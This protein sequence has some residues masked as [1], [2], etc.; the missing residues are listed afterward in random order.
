MDRAGVKEG[1]YEAFYYINTATGEQTRHKPPEFDNY[2]PVTG[3]VKYKNDG[4]K[5]KVLL[6]GVFF[7]K[8][9]YISQQ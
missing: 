6:A 1:R 9:Y 8:Q 3:R 4:R 2:C 5:G 7:T